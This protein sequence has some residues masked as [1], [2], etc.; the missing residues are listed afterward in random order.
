MGRHESKETKR[1]E[2]KMEIIAAADELLE[3]CDKLDSMNAQAL[4][5][6]YADDEPRKMAVRALDDLHRG[7]YGK[8]TERQHAQVTH[9]VQQ[10]T[11]QE[12]LDKANDVIKQ[13]ERKKIDEIK[14]EAKKIR[15]EVAQK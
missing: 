9:I 7:L 14:R 1:E 5:A 6:D 2:A 13:G 4:S 12:E 11:K 10:I 8:L 3:L 15:D